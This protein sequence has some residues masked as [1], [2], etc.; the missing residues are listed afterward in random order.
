MK[1]NQILTRKMGDFNVNQ[2]TSDGMF[3]ATEL[4]KQWDDKS[5]QQKKL[6][7]FFE[8]NSTEEFVSAIVSEENYNTRNSVYLK[9]EDKLDKNHNTG[10]PV[11]KKL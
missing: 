6:D 9:N 3:N 2:R 8:N 11:F 4:L 7:H 10:N 1:T 5:G